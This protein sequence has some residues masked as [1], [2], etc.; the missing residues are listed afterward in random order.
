M[1]LAQFLDVEAAVKAWLSSAGSPAGSRVFYKAQKA[2][3]PYVDLMVVFAAPISEHTPIMRAT[4]Q[5]DC[6]GSSK[7]Q[8]NALGVFVANAAQGLAPGTIMGGVARAGGANV[9]RGPVWFPGEGEPET[10]RY[11][12]DAMFTLTPA[13]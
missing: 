9:T 5:F 6:W 10:P 11:Q 3:M 4:I 2:T 7:Q 1:T 13:S 8:A 12:V